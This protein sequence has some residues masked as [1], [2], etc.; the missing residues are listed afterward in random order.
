MRDWIK[1]TFAALLFLAACAGFATLFIAVS[2]DA[3]AG[4]LQ[5]FRDRG[6][7]H[8]APQADAPKASP[9][10]MQA[11]PQVVEGLGDRVRDRLLLSVVRSRAVDHAV[12]H[13][14][15]VAGGGVRKVTREEARAMAEKVSDETILAA[16]KVY[17]APIGQGKLADLFDW[18]VSHKEQILELVK[19]VLSLFLLFASDESPTP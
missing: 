5:R 4:P 9:K 12:K 13:G 1:G 10:V 14:I 19:F 7:A 2:P 15:P 8:P 3:D 6:K 18:L 16:A 17:G 11:G